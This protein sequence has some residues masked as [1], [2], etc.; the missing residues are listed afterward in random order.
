MI[1]NSQYIVCPVCGKHKFPVQEDK[2]GICRFCGWMHD[3]FAEEEPYS[4]CGGNDLS[5]EDFR[6]R[7]KYYITCNPKY[8]WATDGY[9][10]VPQIEKTKCP[11]CGKYE[12]EPLSWTDIYCGVTPSDVYCMNCGWHYSPEQVRRPDLKE[13]V[14]EMSLNEYKIWYSNKMAENPKFNYFEEQ[15]KNYVPSPHK[16]PVCGKYIFKDDASYEICPYCGW[17]DDGV[18]LSDQDFAGGANDLSL[19]AYRKLYREKIKN[20]PDYRWDK[21]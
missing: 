3:S 5:L 1:K 2:Y 19:R 4:A 21:K 20:D 17:E 13:S 16:C 11:I 9:P 7:Y 18:Q 10:D 12:F 15:T 14:N 6:L 8:H